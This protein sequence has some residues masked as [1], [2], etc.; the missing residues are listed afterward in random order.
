MT[1]ECDACERMHQW[2]SNQTVDFGGKTGETVDF[3]TDDAGTAVTVKAEN[4]AAKVPPELLQQTDAI[5]AYLRN[6]GN[7]VA[8]KTICV[9][10]RAKP[11][12]YIADPTDQLTASE[13]VDKAQAAAKESASSASYA[14]DSADAAMQFAAETAGSAEDAADSASK[15]AASAAAAKEAAEN[16]VLPIASASALG[17]IKVG[18]NL[19][20]AADGTLSAQAQADVPQATETTAGIAKLYDAFGTQTDGGITPRA[21]KDGIG[22][23]ENLPVVPVAK[24][25]L[26]TTSIEDAKA[27][28]EVPE[29]YTLPAATASTLGGVK[30][31]DGL[32]LAS[33]GTLSVDAGNGLAINARTKMLEVPVGD[34]L[35]YTTDGIEVKLG[36]GLSFDANGNVKSNINIFAPMS[37]ITPPT[38]PTSPNSIAFGNSSSAS[39]SGSTAFGTDASAA[40][41]NS[42]ALGRNAKATSDNSIAIGYGSTSTSGNVVSVGTASAV[43]RIVNVGNPINQTDAATKEY[44]DSNAASSYIIVDLSSAGQVNKNSSVDITDSEIVSRFEVIYDSFN[45]GALFGTS[46]SVIIDGNKYSKTCD[47]IRTNESTTGF[48]LKFAIN[49]I[50]NAYINIF[51][52]YILNDSGEFIVRITNEGNYDISDLIIFAL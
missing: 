18:E 9:E 4:G 7:T 8:E 40:G 47:L 26:G 28:L 52:Y 45:D 35:G 42:V 38:W 25:G 21:V 27:L 6:D 43:R 44:V 14:K 12:D 37:V 19:S 39:G 20:I 15:A 46:I 10:G 34:G 13:A 51:V 16:P 31:G 33:D 17:A 24:G 36:D 2:D 48:Y 1:C 49:V 29:A 3:A 22:D 41:M 30:K 50:N 32:K 23:A 11:S 5:K